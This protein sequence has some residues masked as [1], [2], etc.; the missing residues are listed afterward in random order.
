MHR[1]IIRVDTM[2]LKMEEKI[3]NESVFVSVRDEKY[4]L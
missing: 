4:E 1:D 2:W 3:M